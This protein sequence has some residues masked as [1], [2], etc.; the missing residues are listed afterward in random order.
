[1]GIGFESRDLLRL[2]GA[3]VEMGVASPPYISDGASSMG[4]FQTS[5]PLDEDTLRPNAP[6]S[7]PTS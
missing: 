5:P 4:G 3:R 2:T 7:A 1:M 6:S